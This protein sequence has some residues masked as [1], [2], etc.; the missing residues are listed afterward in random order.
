MHHLDQSRGQSDEDSAAQASVNHPSGSLCDAAIERMLDASLNRAAEG[1]RTIEEVARFIVEDAPAASACKTLR[2]DL[3]V[4]AAC[5]PRGDLL[6]GRNTAGDIGTTMTGG[7]ESSRESVAAIVAAAAG[8]T[9]QSLRLIEETMKLSSITDRLK[10]VAS[11]HSNVGPSALVESIRYRFYDVA[12]KVELMLADQPRRERL[13]RCLVYGL[14]TADDSP[15]SFCRNIDRL[16]DAGV[17]VLQLR[18]RNVTD[19]TLLERAR[20]GAKQTRRRGGLFI[21]NDRAD[22]AVAS[23]ADG[24][25]VGQDELP[26]AA[27][28]KIVGPDRLLGLSTHDIDQVRDAADQP[29]D[30]IGCGPV[31]ESRTKSF[32]SHTGASW[33][34]QVSAV[35]AKPAFAIGGIKID[36]VSSVIQTGIGRIAVAGA[37]DDQAADLVDR[38]QA[39]ATEK[40]DQRSGPSGG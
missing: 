30:Y 33:L 31:F 28:R 16:L 25:H 23:D 7:G 9:S 40:S 39:A 10:S 21:V 19:R 8:R 27:V 12:A 38:L 34:N 35:F 6:R 18:D 32:Q 14:I 20:I 24:V 2:H 26:P 22:I 4:V 37:L 5:V 13:N 15:Q 1:L 36:N 29:V 17:M 11:G 3:A